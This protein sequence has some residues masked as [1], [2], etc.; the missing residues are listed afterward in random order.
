MQSSEICWDIEGV[1][2]ATSTA[3]LSLLCNNKVIDHP[4]F[5]KAKYCLFSHTIYRSKPPVKQQTVIPS[6]QAGS[7]C[8]YRSSGTTSWHD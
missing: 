6:N 4:S 7:Q 8:L 5:S 3:L 2:S 1:I